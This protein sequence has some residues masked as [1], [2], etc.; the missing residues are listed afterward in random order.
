[1][2]IGKWDECWYFEDEQQAEEGKT[3]EKQIFGAPLERFP[4]VSEKTA[5][6][7]PGPVTLQ[8]FPWAHGNPRT[9]EW[10]GESSC[11]G[12]TS[13]LKD[14]PPPF[15][16]TTVPMPVEFSGRFLR[17]DYWNSDVAKFGY[18]SLKFLPD[19]T[20]L[21]SITFKLKTRAEQVQ[22]AF[23]SVEVYI[24]IQRVIC[25]LEKSR[26]RI[27]A[28]YL[29]QLL[30]TT[31]Q[32][33]MFKKYLHFW[34]Q[35]W[36]T[37]EGRIQVVCD[38]AQEASRLF[39]TVFQRVTTSNNSR[40]RNNRQFGRLRPNSPTAGSISML[41]S[42]RELIRLVTQEL[43]IHQHLVFEF[44]SCAEATRIK[45]HTRYFE[46]IRSRLQKTFRDGFLA[47]ALTMCR[48]IDARNPAIVRPLAD[49]SAYGDWLDSVSDE[50]ERLQWLIVQNQS[51]IDDMVIA[52]GPGNPQVDNQ[53][54]AIP[55]SSE[56][57]AEN[58]AANMQT[59]ARSSAPLNLEVPGLRRDVFRSI[60][61]FARRTG[62]TRLQR[63]VST[64][65]YIHSCVPRGLGCFV[66]SHRRFTFR[67]TLHELQIYD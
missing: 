63:L 33:P 45:L 15:F 53:T 66:L 44:L 3:F 29:I 9:S 43:Q 46:E 32:A 48:G 25:Y 51:H 39:S 36:E 12:Y 22:T 30:M 1:M 19:N 31:I 27:L 18:H 60:P 23:H 28:T 64:Y 57:S 52:I 40:N 50:L 35:L 67:N 59:N 38:T 2:I 49:Q 8:S 54:S 5:F 7:H 13:Y 41:G 20:N 37:T 6:L 26:K 42:I 11:G 56:S 14:P 55:A 4:T 62:R 61:K 21:M 24:Q 65:Q 58:M 10:Q 47:R 34:K 17:L 16:S